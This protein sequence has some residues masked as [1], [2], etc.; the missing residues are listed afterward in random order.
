MRLA[1]ILILNGVTLAAHDIITTPITWGHE[2]S[3]IVGKHCASCHQPKGQAFSL[4]SYKD[5]R[6]WAV[7]IREEVLKR[8]MPPWGAVKGFGDFRND[9]SLTPEEIELVVKWT[10]GGVPEGEEKTLTPPKSDPAFKIPKG[11]LSIAGPY[12]LAKPLRLTGLYPSKVPPG[13]DTRVI[14]RLPDGRLEPLLWL[15][16]YDPRFGHPFW[17]REPLT[18]PAG[19]AIEGVPLGMTLLLLTAKPSA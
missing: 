1:A 9:N 3:A 18:L 7:A 6:P 12:R 2:I 13:I 15:K 5:A 16:D 17:L 4:L 14:A 8:T 11:A 19:T 10:E